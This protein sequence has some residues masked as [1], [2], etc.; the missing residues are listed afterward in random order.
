LF[1][2]W[3]GG[4]SGP[5]FGGGTYP[6]ATPFGAP[7]YNPNYSGAGSWWPYWPNPA[8][9][10]GAYNWNPQA[11]GIAGQFGQPPEFIRLFQGPR[12]RHAYIHG[13]KSH[14]ALAINDTD[15]ALAFVIPQFLFSS[16]PLYLLP[17]FSFHQW[18]GPR[19]HLDPSNNADLPSKAF[20]AFLDAG[21]QSDPATIFGAELGLRVGMFSDFD[22]VGSESWRVL[23]R[24][25][26]RV[27]LTPQATLKLGVM[28]LDR[29]RVQL[30]P[31][32]G[33]L[34]QPN[35]GTRLDLFF[36]EPKLSSYLTTLGN[37]DTW[38][39][40]AGYYG[41]GAWTIEREDGTQDSIDINDIRLV[42]GLEW[43][44]N[45]MMRDG[46]RAGFAEIG[47]AFDRELLYKR[48][49][50]DNLDLQDNFVVRVGFG[51]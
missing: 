10:T 28:Y 41:G 14:N 9:T 39:Y 44:R 46:R 2:D 51:Y 45:D 7:G 25:I 36:P 21:W 15:V 20:S 26:G 29:N 16:Q 33:V 5:G 32:G 48:R 49:P 22:A 31:A 3:S 27:R 19:A 50:A 42:V 4:S 17:S 8:G 40:V 18:S 30:L 35:P 12:F 47:Y 43:G 38:W 11:T 1:G 23:G 13:D 24:A 37:K 34:W 6:G